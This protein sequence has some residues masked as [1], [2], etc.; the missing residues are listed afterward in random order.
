MPHT[1]KRKNPSPTPPASDIESDNAREV[2]AS[3]QRMKREIARL[4][5]RLSA[6]TDGKQK[7]EEYVLLFIIS[8]TRLTQN[9]CSSD[10][11][12]WS[13]RGRA[14]ARC[15]ATFDFPETLIAEYDRRAEIDEDSATEDEDEEPAAPT[16]ECVT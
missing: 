8:P 1:N 9:L 15:I 14:F 12:T 13:N 5:D 16:R 2:L 4:R 3:T 7:V 6:A 10:R 11:K